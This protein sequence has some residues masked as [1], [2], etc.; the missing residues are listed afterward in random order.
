MST[1]LLQFPGRMPMRSVWKS[2]PGGARWRS[3]SLRM[4]KRKMRSL[5]GLMSQES[6]QCFLLEENHAFAGIVK[7]DEVRRN[8]GRRA[9]PEITDDERRIDAGYRVSDRAALR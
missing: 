5:K 9:V 1:A 6:R 2:M 3:R 7:L 8:R 4:L